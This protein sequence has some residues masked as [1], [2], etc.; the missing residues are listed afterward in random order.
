MTPTPWKII[1]V[2]PITCALDPNFSALLTALGPDLSEGECLTKIH[3][4]FTPT[5]TPVPPSW[6]EEA[7]GNLYTTLLYQLLP[8]KGDLS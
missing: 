6:D 2:Y 5:G 7:Y 8:T 4:H 1:C 3:E